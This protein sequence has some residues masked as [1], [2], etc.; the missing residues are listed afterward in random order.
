VA[1]CTKQRPRGLGSGGDGGAAAERAIL[2]R[3]P[4]RDQSVIKVET[5]EGTFRELGKRRGWLY[6]GRHKSD[7]V[8][9]IVQ[10]PN[11]VG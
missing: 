11:R 4:R 8:T 10:G 1:A 5:A 9:K 6:T 3:T 2:R 7:R